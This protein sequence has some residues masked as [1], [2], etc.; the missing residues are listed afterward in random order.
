MKH[1][2]PLT[3][4]QTT[5]HGYW[6]IRDKNN[7]VVANDIT[8]EKADFLTTAANAHYPNQAKIDEM[9]AALQVLLDAIDYTS[10]NCRVNEMVGAVLPKELIEK[11]KAAIAQAKP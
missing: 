10:G 1:L 7:L 9:L 6:E 4:R 2:L 3:F 8:Q 11:A 5:I